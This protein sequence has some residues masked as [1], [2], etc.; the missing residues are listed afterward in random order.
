MQS[1]IRHISL[2]IL[3]ISIFSCQKKPLNID[4]STIETNQSFFRMEKDLFQSPDS[5]LDKSAWL[6]EKYNEFFKI[7]TSEMIRIGT[8]SDSLY[9]ILLKKFRTDT[10]ITEVAQKVD[11]VFKDFTPIQNKITDA[12]KR[13]KYH[14]PNKTVPN[15]YTCISGFNQNIVISTDI[16]AVSLDKYLGKAGKKFYSGLMTPLYKQ[17]NMI[18]EKVPADAML[19]WA[20]TE[21]AYNDSVD[22]LLSQMIYHGKIMYFI[23]AMLPNTPDT[24]KM[25]Y[26]AQQLQFCK[27]SEPDFWTYFIEQKLLYKTEA[28]IKRRYIKNSPYTSDFTSKSPGRTGV[29]IG[30]QIVRQ[31]M[32]NN[33]QITVKELMNNHNYQKILNQSGYSPQY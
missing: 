26:T 24:L 16:L 14:F 19:G 5:L 25:G 17:K 1:M 7:F 28:T 27:N 12:F 8:P 18:P 33:P 11:S 20:Y 10:M 6:E 4:I 22:N 13:Y 2:I 31:Y 15:I 30:W 29:W 9:P 3:V 21:F 23:D 32:K